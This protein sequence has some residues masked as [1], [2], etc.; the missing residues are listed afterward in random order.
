METTGDLVRR[1]E[2]G[3]CSMTKPDR[4]Q[5]L[6]EHKLGDQGKSHA[7]KRMKIIPP[8]ST[9]YRTQQSTV[10]SQIQRPRKRMRSS[11]S[12]QHTSSLPKYP[13]EEEALI[14]MRYYS[15]IHQG[16][17]PE[18]EI[19]W[20]MPEPVWWNLTGDMSEDPIAWASGQNC[21]INLFWDD[22]EPCETIYGSGAQWDWV[23]GNDVGGEIG[24]G[25]A[26]RG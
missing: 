16:A 18:D 4:I 9:T 7:L 2:L 22:F 12:P 23:S 1:R 19:R 15:R 11:P 8:S 13:Q 20:L 24:S 26:G 21:C 25:R 14:I 5:Q 17:A 6:V 3:S 10:S